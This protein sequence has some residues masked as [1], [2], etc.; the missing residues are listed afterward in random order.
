M[1]KLRKLQ[2]TN[3]KGIYSKFEID[4]ESSE[5]VKVNVLSGPNGFGKTTVFDAIE[6]CLTGKLERVQKFG[7]VQKN[8]ANRNRPYFQNVDGVDVV[9]KLWLRDD[10]NDI[11]IIKYYDDDQAPSKVNSGRDNIP[12][13]STNFF[14][15]F[16]ETDPIY[17]VEDDFTGL[18]PKGQK[19]VDSIVYGSNSRGQLASIYYLF[20]YIQ[21]E[22]S[23]YF[24]RQS[25]DDKGESLSFLFN[26]EEEEAKL[27]KLD[28][29]REILNR[30]NNLLREEIR[31]LNLAISDADKISY[32]RIFLNKE[33]GFDLEHPFKNVVTAKDEL[34]KFEELI[35]ELI[36]FK[37]TFN[38]DEYEKSLK[39][40]QLNTQVIQNEALL[41]HLVIK[42]IYSKEI[43]E[44]ILADNDKI[45]KARIFLDFQKDNNIDKLY[46]ELFGDD[47][48]YS[49]YLEY[50]NQI[51]EINKELGNIGKTI[52]EL[53]VS[54]EKCIKELEKIKSH[55]IISD[56]NCPLCDTPFAS[57]DELLR[58][59]AA[60]TELLISYDRVKLAQKQ[61]LVEAISEIVKL[62]QE[63]ANSFLRTN[64]EVESSIVDLFRNYP[65][66]EKLIEQVLE[67]Y[68]ALRLDGT[69]DYYFTSFPLSNAVVEEKVTTLKSFIVEKVLSIY[70]YNESLILRKN[71]YI[72]YLE[73]SPSSLSELSIDQLNSKREYLKS[74][75]YLVINE[76]LQFLNERIEKLLQL[77]MYINQTYT[78]VYG[79]I[80]EH[81]SGMINKIKIPFYVYSGK[82]LQSYQQ[83]L[84]IFVEIHKTELSNYVR[85]KTGSS[86]D[87]DVI[88]HLSS[89]QMAVVSLAFCFALNKVYSTNHKFKFLAIDDPIQ[90]MDDLNIHT[91]IELI[92]NEFSEYQIIMSTHDDFTSRYMKYKFD[93][94]GME[95][96]I[97]NMQQLTL[98]QADN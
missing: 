30:Q 52:S 79:V 61:R 89:G 12:I 95:T 86:S 39:F 90:T 94:F 81:K 13:D 83:G 27:K 5:S 67:T 19:D 8:T 55:N 1:L 87:H 51:T 57:F 58:A 53:N 11:I 23:I 6:I 85:F 47:G 74:E 76:R 37:E 24:L 59:V 84:G 45:Q 65:N 98:T 91:F 69:S 66:Y 63:N 35:R 26:I 29:L 33:F 60:K 46:F 2:I 15:T 40:Q 36:V 17:F 93:K 80:K 14:T 38:V 92:R 50:S 64:L 10:D 71:L 34:A 32:S 28:G 82:V 20:N 48:N 62:L 41:K 68:P 7:N 78:E 54:R 77:Q 9:L 44:R 18:L 22:D 31:L 96:V 97:Q 25:E 3:F 75:Y 70:G 72:D 49:S 73:G 43:L 16:L 88:F 4:F 21:Q 42:N 56:S